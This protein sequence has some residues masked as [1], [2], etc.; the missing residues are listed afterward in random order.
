M[1]HLALYRE[2]RPQRFADVVGQQHITRTLRNALTQNRMHHAYL[3]SGPRGTGKTTVARILAKAVNCLDL[4]QGEPCNACKA[5][6]SIMAGETMDVIEIDA[7]S[8]RG[9]DEIRDLRD[10]VKYAPADLKYK[11]YII[12]EV[13]ML[14]EPAFNALLKTLEEPPGHVL[15]VLATTEKQKLPITILSRCQAF[16]Y[17]RLSTPEIMGRLQEVCAKYELTATPEALTAI[18]RQAEGGMR[19]ALSLLDQVMAYAAD[20]RITLEDTLHV[21]GSAPLDQF[22]QLDAQLAKGEVGGALLWLDEMVRQGKD[23]RQLVRDYLAHLRDLL[24]L[25]VDTGGAVLDLPP[26]ALQALKEQAR[27]MEQ[28]H[29]LTGIRLLAQVESEMRLSASPRLLV[30]VGLIRLAG[31]FADQEVTAPAAAPQPTPPRSRQRSTPAPAPPPA[32]APADEPGNRAPAEAAA[33]PPEPT[34][35]PAPVGE[36]VEK[37]VQVW[38]QVI[39][40][41]RRK[42]PSTVPLIQNVRVGALRGSTLFLVATTPT[43]AQLLKRKDDKMILEKALEHLGLTGLEIQILGPDEALRIQVAPTAQTE[44]KQEAAEQ[45]LLEKVQSVFPKEIVHEVKEEGSK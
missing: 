13:H 15:F 28:S 41:I 17:H 31:L 6:R 37:V 10:K 39:E 42:R 27:A 29:I 1:A 38:D 19:D 14:S 18:A 34:A 45:S 35:P 43:F 8:N 33:A 40:L 16:E 22:L 12:D 32:S 5:C 11:V 44:T 30:E 26:Q 9:I 23:L 24:L 25:K 4:T 2:F 21:L 7:A 3:L 36:G 20:G